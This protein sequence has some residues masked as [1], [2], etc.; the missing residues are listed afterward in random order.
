MPLLL[1]ERRNVAGPYQGSFDQR[2]VLKQQIQ[3]KIAERQE[4]ILKENIAVVSLAPQTG[5]QSKSS[6]CQCF[7]D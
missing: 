6:M 1:S 7:R 4:L 2:D 5:L 3:A